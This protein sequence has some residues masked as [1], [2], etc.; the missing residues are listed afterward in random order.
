MNGLLSQVHD[1]SLQMDLEGTLISNLLKRSFL[2]CEAMEKRR[3]RV[4]V[5]DKISLS[6]DNEAFS[7]ASSPP[8]VAQGIFPIYIYRIIVL[9]F[10]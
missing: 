8:T 5:D 4:I 3:E 10:R 1:S 7:T 9:C 2:S 6:E